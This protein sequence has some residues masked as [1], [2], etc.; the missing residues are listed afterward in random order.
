MWLLCWGVFVREIE[1]MIARTSS[2]R[3]VRVV[4][5]VGIV[6]IMWVVWIVR[7]LVVDRASCN[8]LNIR[9]HL[10]INLYVVLIC[11]LVDECSRR[12]GGKR[13]VNCPRIG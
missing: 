10:H 9:F 1:H 6:G 3:I 4:R 8:F 5:V 2:R 13:K 7:L 11:G 12:I